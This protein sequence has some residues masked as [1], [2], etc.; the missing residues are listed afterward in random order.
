[1]GRAAVRDDTLLTLSEG[2]V[3]GGGEQAFGAEPRQQRN[4]DQM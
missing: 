3:V 1:M 4:G 2:P